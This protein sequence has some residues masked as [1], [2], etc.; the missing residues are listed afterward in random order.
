MSLRTPLEQFRYKRI[1][2]KQGSYPLCDLPAIREWNYWKLVTPIS[3]H[4]RHH[5][6]HLMIVLKR[7]CSDIW[8]GIHYYELAELWRIVLP[9]LDNEHHYFKINFKLMR[10]VHGYVHFHVMKLKKRYQ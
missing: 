8:Q 9:S 3:K 6:D 10:S 4:N 7:P 2:N 1:L 5:T